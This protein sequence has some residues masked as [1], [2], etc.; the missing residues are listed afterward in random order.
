MIS[1]VQ[2]RETE[3]VFNAEVSEG[4]GDERF[5]IWKSLSLLWFHIAHTDKC[6]F[7]SQQK[8]NFGES[9]NLISQLM[10]T[11]NCAIIDAIDQL[12]RCVCFAQS[13]FSE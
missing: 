1:E 7:V 6:L 13:I 4:S 2:K 9:Q 5:E 8:K 10:S 3:H 12:I 11:T